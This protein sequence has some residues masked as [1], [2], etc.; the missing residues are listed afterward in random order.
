[1]TLKN[2]LQVENF[3]DLCSVSNIS[4][5]IFDESVHG[6]YIHGQ[7]PGGIS[8]VTTEEIE[9]I[10]KLESK[11]GLRGRGLIPTDP[12]NLQTFEILVPWEMRQEYQG[13]NFQF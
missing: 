9:K 2:P 12:Y 4:I 10:L 8:E 7:S 13:V 1:M 5:F 11:G 6:Y 3:I